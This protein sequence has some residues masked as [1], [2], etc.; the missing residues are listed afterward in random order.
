MGHPLWCLDI[1]NLGGLESCSARRDWW[2][3]KAVV[4]WVTDSGVSLSSWEISRM[5]G[6]VAGRVA[7]CLA[8]PA[9]LL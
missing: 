4:L 8:M 6:V 9:S 5:A 2:S 3:K 7:I 1:R